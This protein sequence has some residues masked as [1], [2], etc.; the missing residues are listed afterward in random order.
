[1]LLPIDM[2]VAY[3]RSSTGESNGVR[4]RQD[5]ELNLTDPAP[6]PPLD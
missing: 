3:I 5:L 2:E 4:R 1:M 6:L